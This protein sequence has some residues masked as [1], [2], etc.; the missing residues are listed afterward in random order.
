M[1]TTIGYPVVVRPSYVLGGRAMKIVYNQPEL[2]N[3]ARLA[4]LASPGHPVLIDKFLEDAIEMDVDAIS[5]GNKAVI[6][7]IMEHIEA[8]GVHSGDSACVL[9]PYTLGPDMLEE[10]ADAT[11]AMAH[12][13]N[14]VGLMN[15]QYAIK[16]NR[17]FVIEVNPRAS[18]TIPFVSKATGIPLAKMATKV[19]LGRTL[20]ELGSWKRSFRSTFPSKKRCCPLTGS[21][22]W[23]PCWGR[24]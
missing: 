17:L 21:R 1:R 14:V 12:E 6:G 5:D 16:D 10:I 19:M 7:G 4:I 3:F 24:K 15:V 11:K 13:L 18:R 22:T 2:E 9:P 23:T 8:A 20:E